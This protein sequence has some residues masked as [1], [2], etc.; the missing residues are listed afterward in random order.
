MV[1]VNPAIAKPTVSDAFMFE[2]LNFV[3]SED[4]ISTI[5]K[6]LAKKVERGEVSFDGITSPPIIYISQQEINN[7]FMP[8]E[9]NAKTV[10]IVKNIRAVYDDNPDSPTF[11]SIYLLDTWDESNVFDRETLIHEMVHHVQ[12]Y[13]NVNNMKSCGAELEAAAYKIGLT[14]LIE[15]GATDEQIKIRKWQMFIFSKCLQYR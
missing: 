3:T 5:S 15:N 14:Y 11:G 12:Q 7:R 2:A 13:A 4:S 6:W 8:T 1:L 9:T 10:S